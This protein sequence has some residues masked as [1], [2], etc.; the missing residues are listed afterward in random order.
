VTHLAKDYKTYKKQIAQEGKKEV[1]KGG[2]PN[3]GK[4]REGG[5][6]RDEF[7]NVEDTKLIFGGPWP[8][9][10]DGARS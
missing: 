4:H 1:A 9:R 3:N 6:D 2:H 8:T 10:T 7:P 5:N